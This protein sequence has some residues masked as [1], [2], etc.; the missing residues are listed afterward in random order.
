VRAFDHLP[1]DAR[2]HLALR[3]YEAVLAVVLLAGER[4]GGEPDAVLD[5]HPFLR[6]YLAELAARLPREMPLDEAA[7]WLRTE[8]RAWEAATD[9]RL[10]L[11]AL[12]AELGLTDAQGLALL[13]AGMVEEDARFGEVFAEAQGGARRPAAGFVHALV[14]AVA[15]AERAAGDAWAL[16]RPL[17]DAG[18]VEAQNPADPRAEWQ[19]RVPVALWTVLAGETPAQPLPGVRHH[20]AADALPLDRMVLDEA[21]HARLEEARALL[22]AGSAEALVLR[23]LPGSE[24]VEAAAAVARALG[25]GVLQAAPPGASVPEGWKALGP[26]ATLLGAI[27][28]FILELGPGETFEV[29]R[30]G[31]YRGPVIV[32]AGHD[33][34][35]GGP[36]AEHA[37]TLHLRPE[38]PELRRRHWARALPDA[39]PRLHADLARRYTLGGR[40]VRRV[41]ELARAQAAMERRASIDP[42]DVRA[43]AR[44]LNRQ[45]LDSLAARM[46]D[47]GGWERLVL[48]PSTADELRHLERRCRH[49]EGLTRALGGG[50]PGGMNRGVRALFQG[51]SGTGKT[52]AARVLACELGLDLYR[53]DL[54]SLVSK[55]I[56]ETEKNLGRILARAE[57]L[58]VVL[59]LDEGDSL[60]GRRT[61]VRSSNDRWANLET[62]YLLQ[63][64]DGYTGIV[65]VTT[66]LPGSIDPAF[67]RRMDAVVRF[68]L[69]DVDERWALW[70]AHLPA[71]HEVDDEA[72]E[73]AARFELSGGQIRN[74]AVDAALLGLAAGGRLRPGHVAA[75]VEAEYRKAG[76]A[77]PR[78]RVTGGAPHADRLSAFLGSIS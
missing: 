4:A 32:V 36:V 10:P 1:R 59:L 27:P 41:A 18:L 38:T 53:V 34:G 13:L 64:L 28:L 23:G 21:E 77:F 24:R 55:Y 25:R 44:S 63:R 62:N 49:R 14:S 69:P 75:A 66:N 3:F 60:L 43:A 45:Q 40:Y 42:E 16:V 67:Q 50:L 12:T 33:G 22:A 35:I 52:L 47:G 72:L 56:G 78:G 19:L 65:L 17:L 54:S 39:E 74:A 15:D 73:D 9:A 58:D 31:G 26:L 57:D 30:W 20:P 29:P 46:E 2:G 71:G 48:H 61:E 68:H 11:R 5:R 76:A 6:R 8:T 37:V 51:P 70:Q 7:R